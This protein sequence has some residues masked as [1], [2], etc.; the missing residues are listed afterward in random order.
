MGYF[1]PKAELQRKTE[2]YKDRHF[3]KK[4]RD[5]QEFYCSLHFYFC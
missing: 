4:M 1:K 2:K 5:Q 3:G